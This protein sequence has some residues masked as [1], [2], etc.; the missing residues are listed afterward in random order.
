MGILRAQ[1]PFSQ[2]EALKQIYSQYD[3]QKKTAKWI[4]VKDQEH[5][6]WHFFRGKFDSFHYSRVDGRSPRG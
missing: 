5:S 2:D 6:A 4:Y 3:A 1:Q